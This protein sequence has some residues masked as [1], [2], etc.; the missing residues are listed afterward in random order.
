MYARVKINYSDFLL[1]FR[2]ANTWIHPF[3]NSLSFK[4]RCKQFLFLVCPCPWRECLYADTI[5]LENTSPHH[6]LWYRSLQVSLRN[7]STAGTSLLRCSSTSGLISIYESSRSG[8]ARQFIHTFVC[9]F[10][11]VFFSL[12]FSE[13][14]PEIFLSW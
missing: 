14:T 11:F 6:N 7:V 2:W 5:A 9:L 3:K 8:K 12:F 10:L 13:W 1:Y 4:A